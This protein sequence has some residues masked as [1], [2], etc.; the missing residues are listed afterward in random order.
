MAT[1]P[2]R[3]AQDT[4][5][6]R[7]KKGTGGVWTDRHGQAWYSYEDEYEKRHSHRAGSEQHAEMALAEINAAKA[8]RLRVA[9]GRQS[10]AAFL[11]TWLNTEIAPAVESGETKPR[12]LEH[13]IKLVN[14]Y[15]VP[16]IGRY[17]LID[18]T[19]PIIGELR[20][21]LRKNLVS[22]TVNAV[23]GL[24]SRALRDAVAWHY[25]ASN[26]A[27]KDSVKRV[28]KFV[29]EEDEPLSEQQV[30][31]L[32]AVAR[33]D[34]PGYA[35]MAFALEVKAVTG[36]RLG[37]LF[38]LRWVDVDLEEGIITIAQQIQH[39]EGV[40]PE[41]SIIWKSCRFIAPKTAASRRKITLPPRLLAGWKAFYQAERMRAGEFGLVFTTRNGTPVL[42]TNFALLFRRWVEK[43]NQGGAGIV[44]R[45]HS[46]RHFCATLLG[47]S[48]AQDVV[49]Q[50]LLGHGKKGV[51]QRY[52]TSRIPKMREAMNY[53]EAQLW[54]VGERA[55]TGT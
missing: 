30:R 28:R 53:V 26:P 19:P 17:A 23:L 32:I 50:A 7:R 3:Q 22:D 45:S 33:A 29:G 15:I 31:A 43:A 9:D 39:R 41:G 4:A 40:D 38:G 8:G 52:Q 36:V 20:N 37:E 27:G 55:E 18:L 5:R 13:Y 49:V 1:T 44:A 16:F 14:S 54:S 48:G 12:T 46:L 21:T 42:P 35:R 6:P 10:L 2:R 51:T 34:T 24:L 11:E 47:E 25:I